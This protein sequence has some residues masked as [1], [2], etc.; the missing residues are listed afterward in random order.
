[1]SLILELRSCIYSYVGRNLMLVSIFSSSMYLG[2]FVSKW[3]LLHV[4]LCSVFN[5]RKWSTSII[6]T[7]I[8]IFIR[9]IDN[10]EDDRFQQVNM[11]WSKYIYYHKYYFDI[12]LSIK[13]RIALKLSY[14]RLVATIFAWLICFFVYYLAIIFEKHKFKISVNLK[15]YLKNKSAIMTEW[16]I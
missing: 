12:I 13:K 9:I 10:K 6:V 8:N 7:I 5:F 1:M 16:H 4:M 2:S 11:C 15:Y 14:Y 3:I